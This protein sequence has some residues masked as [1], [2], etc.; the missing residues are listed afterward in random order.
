MGYS[1]GERKSYYDKLHEDV[2][3]A[4]QRIDYIKQKKYRKENRVIYYQDE[5]WLNKNMMA[6]KTWVLS[7][8]D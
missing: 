2:D 1:Y 3:I 5:T 6:M 7:Q 4:S 8:Q